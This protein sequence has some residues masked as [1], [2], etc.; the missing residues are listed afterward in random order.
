MLRRTDGGFFL[1]THAYFSVVRFVERRLLPYSV[2]QK[3]LFPPFI[4][5]CRDLVGRK[6]QRESRRGARQITRCLTRFPPYVFFLSVRLTATRKY[7]GG[8]DIKVC[9]EKKHRSLV[10]TDEENKGNN[11]AHFSVCAGGSCCWWWSE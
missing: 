4:T 3:F 2:I 7:T 11:I 9:R 5:L 6:T 1:G 8:A 10:P